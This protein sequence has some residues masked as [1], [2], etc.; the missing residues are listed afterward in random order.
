VIEVTRASAGVYS[1]RFAGLAREVGERD[2]VQVTAY[3]AAPSVYCKPANLPNAVVPGWSTVGSDLIA[4]VNCFAASDGTPADSRFTILLIGAQAFG[5]STPVGFMLAT[6]DSVSSAVMDTSVTAR[7]STGGHIYL[8]RVSEG[9]YAMQFKGLGSASAGKP[10]ALEATAVGA[11]LRRCRIGAVDQA[12]D[13]VNVLCARAGGGRGDS[14]FSVL[15]FTRGRPNRRFGFAWANDPGS[16]VDYAPDASFAFNSGGGSI[17]ARRT[18]TGQYR[19]V[20]AGLGRPA[21]ATENVQLSLAFTGASLIVC[22]I[23]SWGT[24]GVNDLTVTVA[25][26]DLDGAPAN[27]LFNLLVVE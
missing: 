16:I 24:T 13:G 26:F 3:A 12:N 8:T 6:G 20:F 18:G 17:L 10:I 19:V 9:N 4:P 7:N 23:A 15:W 2:N 22:D 25:C 21:G 27:A 11:G 1:V 5:S 14:P